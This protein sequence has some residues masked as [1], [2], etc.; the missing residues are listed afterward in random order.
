MGPGLRPAILLLALAAVA[1]CS[2]N[3]PADAMVNCQATEVLPDAVSTDILFVVDDSGSMSEEQANLA[4]NLDAFIDTLAAS[5]VKNDFRIGVTNSSVE[6]FTV[7]ATSG[8]SYASGP[9]SGVPYPA[10]ALVAIK[11]DAS[12]NASPG[13]LVYD[14]SLYPQTG[15]WG[16]R[17]ILDKSSPTLA[18]DFKVNVRVGLDGSGKEQPFRAARLALSDRL[19][20]ANAGFLRDGARLAIVFLTDEDDCSDSSDPRATSNDQCHDKAVKNASPPILDTVEDFA[21]FLLGPVGGQLRDVAVG[22][23]GGFDPANLSPSCGDASLCPDTA[24][25]T[26][27]D[28][29]DRFAALAAA[30]GSTRTQLGSICDA[31]FRNSLIR[32]AASLTPSSMP[33]VGA[34]ADWRMLTV[35]VTKAAGAVVPCSVALDGTAG[36]STAD[37][38]FSGPQAGRQAQIAFQNACKLDLGDK[39]DVR[40]VCAG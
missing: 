22:V 10:G 19:L 34:P 27:Y 31:S 21:A 40:V 3:A 23:I 18:S 39:I 7:T 17:R 36:Q 25:S 14:A 5:P 24:C 11:T 38:V 2:D 8:K 26:A 32:F 20:D 35:T 29:A 16:G 13:A 12:G 33:L 28:E 4:A 30:L 6:E 1:A 9:S 15:G 37:A